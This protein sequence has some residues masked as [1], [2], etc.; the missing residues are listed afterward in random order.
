MTRD[1]SDY[2]GGTIDLA[3]PTRFLLFSPSTDSTSHTMADHS[4]KL[5]FEYK[6]AGD[7][8]I[9]ADVYLPE[10]VQRALSGSLAPHLWGDQAC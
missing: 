7:V 1:E 10:C 4:T 8:S 2:T 6:K 5:T 3:A 9:K